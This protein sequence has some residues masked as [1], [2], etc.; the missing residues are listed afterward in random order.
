[1]L[2]FSVYHLENQLVLNSESIQNC[3]LFKIQDDSHR[4][5]KNRDLIKTP[6][7]LKLYFP[8]D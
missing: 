1:M 6:V 4:Q 8:K 5:I 2:G 3:L 7:P